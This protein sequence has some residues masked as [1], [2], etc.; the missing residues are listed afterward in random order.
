MSKWVVNNVYLTGCSLREKAYGLQMGGEM[1]S[2]IKHLC[3]WGTV[4]QFRFKCKFVAITPRQS[5]R[6]ASHYLI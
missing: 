6:G 3:G 5:P 1:H 4:G 2:N